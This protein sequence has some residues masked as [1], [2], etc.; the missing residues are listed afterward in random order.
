MIEMEEIF[1][2]I[3]G[4]RAD[5]INLQADLTSKVALA[6]ENEGEGEHDKADYLKKKLEE[7]NPDLIEEI[8]APDER[9]R[10]GY[11]PNLVAKW[12][13]E[14]GG[15]SVWVLSH[16]D[17]VPPGDLSLWESDP[18][19]IKVEGDKV[20]GRG[21]EDNHH[22]IISSYLALK[23]IRQSGVRLK[24]PVGLVLVADEET[25]S[26]YGLEYLLRNHRDFF[27]AEDL[28]VVPDGG[29]EEG[30]MIE[31]AEK[32]MLWVKFTVLGQ[33]CHASTPDKGKNSLYGAA[34][35]IVALGKLKD[36]FGLM[37]GLYSPPLSTFEPTKMETN[38]PNINTIPGRDV[39]HIDC[40]I[41][42]QYKVDDVLAAAQRIAEELSE[43]LDLSLLVEP[44]YRQDA[45]IP[46]SADAPV[47]KVLARAIKTVTGLDAKPM[48]IGGGTVAAF[49]REAGVPA[50]VWM[51][52]PNT[53]HQ[54]NEY[55]LIKNIISDAKVFACIYLDEYGD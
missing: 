26:R 13:G 21:V 45:A 42:P 47:V 4:Y 49:F 55:C 19:E 9:A 30:S 2:Q 8:K 1:S 3:E 7:L 46:T 43:E 33:Q 5:I 20:F 28:I 23:A 38:N 35:L 25:G 53:A 31:V 37:D 51:T 52:M 40:R 41:L 22:G 34:R 32:S 36:E 6:P 50:A 11:R 16:I 54:P 44:V 27:R 12:E 48:G 10:N 15:S 24:R 18:Y 17:V 39:F 29:N 14:N